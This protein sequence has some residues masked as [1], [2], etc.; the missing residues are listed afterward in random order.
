[1]A[2]QKRFSAPVCH[3]YA[4][5]RNPAPLAI[6]LWTNQA[7]RSVRR[8]NRGPAGFFHRLHE[9]IIPEQ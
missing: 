6:H 9:S 4:T 8:L 7:H 3:R 5:G 2:A 1:M